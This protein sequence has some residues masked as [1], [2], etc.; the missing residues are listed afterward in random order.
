[1]KALVVAVCMAGACSG[2]SGS[3][4]DA[5]STSDAAGSNAADAPA[6]DPNDPVEDVPAFTG[7]YS[8]AKLTT[9]ESLT[10]SAGTWFTDST[11]EH[12]VSDIETTYARYRDAMVLQSTFAAKIYIYDQ[13][14]GTVGA[15]ID[16]PSDAVGT[17][18]IRGGLVYI[19]GA[20]KLYSYELA[21]RMWRTRTVPGAGACHHLAAGATR[22]F[23]VCTD[24][25]TIH[26]AYIV[27]TWANK[28][29]SDVTPVG[30]FAPG[31]GADFSWITAA[32]GGDTAYLASNMPGCV[33]RATWN[34]LDPCVFSMRT[35]TT[36]TD[37]AVVDAAATEDGSLLD[38]SF[39]TQT[40]PGK[41][42]YEVTLTAQPMARSIRPVEAYATCPDGSVVF[43]DG[44]GSWRRAGGVDT[45]VRLGAGGARYMGCPLKKQ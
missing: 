42:L 38:V 5:A 3:S 20:G 43:Q 23:A 31:P 24:A 14:T 41:H 32:P 19:G 12:K 16:L 29:M 28:T 34:A 2:N 8:F 15:A 21:T 7:V 30:T 45:D 37:A 4:I 9:D 10:A 36:D 11:T 6:Q 18:I 1:M 17:A 27:S 39:V 13:A 33:A 35:L 25:T 22:L 40:D 26:N 44:V